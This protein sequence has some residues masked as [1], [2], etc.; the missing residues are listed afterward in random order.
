MPTLEHTVSNRNG[1]QVMVKGLSLRSLGYR[2]DVRV[3]VSDPTGIHADAVWDFVVSNNEHSTLTSKNP[4]PPDWIQTGVRVRIDV[5]DS[6]AVPL[7]VAVRHSRPPQP[8]SVETLAAWRRSLIQIISKIERA[9]HVV[10]DGGVANR[11]GIL[12][13]SGHLPREV[14]QFMRTVTELRN[15]AEYNAKILTPT[16][17]EAASAAW[18]AI[19]EWAQAK[20]ISY[21]L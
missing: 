2:K 14:A 16:E 20:G 18:R 7:G 17:S 12:T 1:S 21:P 15:E 9:N 3:V 6:G 13:R 19:V 4:P 5:Q 10:P 11:I 8:V